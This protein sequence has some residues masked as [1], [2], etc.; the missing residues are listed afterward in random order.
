MGGALEVSED[1]RRDGGT[2]V[3]VVVVLRG[4]QFWGPVVESS[5]PCFRPPQREA[6]TPAAGFSGTKV[7]A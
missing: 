3:P 1:G 2:S 4:S 7:E 5:G 6:E